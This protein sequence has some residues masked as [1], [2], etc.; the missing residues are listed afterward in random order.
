MICSRLHEISGLQKG[1][2]DKP[3]EATDIIW[4]YGG[5]VNANFT[6]I[7]RGDVNVN[8]KGNL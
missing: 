6:W 2:L 4:I 5:D 7:Y 3:G 1:R 8:F